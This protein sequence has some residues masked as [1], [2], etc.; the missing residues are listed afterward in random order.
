MENEITELDKLYFPHYWQKRLPIDRI[1]DSSIEFCNKES[2]LVKKTVK[3]EFD[4]PYGF[5]QR[6][7]YSIFGIDLPPDA[8]ILIHVHG[9]YW[10]LEKIHHNN[11]LFLA[12]ILHKHGV[13]VISI[14]YQLCPSVT[15]KQIIIQV[16]LA[17]KK[18]LTYAV[19]CKSRSVYLTGHSAGAHLVSCLF[20]T[21][22]NTLSNEEQ[23]LIKAV[24]LS[25]GLYDA[26]P[27]IKTVIN[28][29]LRLTQD[30]ALEISPQFMNI[31]SPAHI[32]FY[33]I[34]AEHDTPVFREQSD[35]FYAKLKENGFKVNF[36]LL[37]N[38]DHFNA[39]ENMINEE[40]EIVKL[41]LRILQD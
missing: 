3:C 10:H 5:G 31:S 35:H 12:K 41:L 22:I 34:A 7:K 39:I 32:N 37:R 30:S 16:E 25:C 1:L 27:L 17:L 4:I 14:G 29:Q 11:Q 28:Q 38:L 20:S 15:I 18:C 33:V 40:H 21:F 24:F 8:P 23:Q 26:T 36:R 2:E 13:K 6:E 19:K 9:G